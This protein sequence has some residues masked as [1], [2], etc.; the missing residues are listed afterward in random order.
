MR[1]KSRE[2]AARH[3]HPPDYPFKEITVI[4]ALKGALMAGV[5]LPRDA[6]SRINLGQAFAEY[7]K[8]LLRPGIIVETPALRAAFDPDRSKCFFVGRRGTGKTAI[9]RYVR[10]RDPR[11]TTPL[12]PL[13]F[14]P[15]AVPISL[16]AFSDTRQK[17]C[18]TA[19]QA[20]TRALINEAI[21]TWLRAGYVTIARVQAEFSRERNLI[22]QFDFDGR[23]LHY[24]DEAFEALASNER[25]W[26]RFMNRVRDLGTSITKLAAETQ[27]TCTIVIDRLDE[28]W[29]GSEK[30]VLFL[31][32]LMHACVQISTSIPSLR[33]LLFLRENIFERIRQI[34]NEFARLNRH[35]HSC[36]MFGLAG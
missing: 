28:A 7:D 6:L 25:E 13:V 24:F 10:D 14:V 21:S 3:P 19:I 30:A 16:S 29:D 34:D 27:L 11:R 15:E 26:M 32:A 8:I 12:T 4:I 1:D 33:P 9:T 36:D 20:Y 5:Q 31:M 23:L 18:R 35:S 2:H 17:P 22:E